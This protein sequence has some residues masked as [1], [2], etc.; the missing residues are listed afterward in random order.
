MGSFADLHLSSNAQLPA[1]N[2]PKAA[3][4]FGW[5]RQLVLIAALLLLGMGGGMQR[6]TA[7]K[8]WE[9]GD[10][11]LRIQFRLQ[12]L[13]YSYVEPTG[14]YDL[15]TQRAIM[16]FQQRIG[17][18][19]D[20]VV[21]RQTR[22]VLFD[23]FDPIVGAAESS[24][25]LPS[26]NS[27]SLEFPPE[28]AT[29]PQSNSPSQGFPP[30]G[31][32]YSQFS[33]PDFPSQSNSIDPFAVNQRLGFRP[34]RR[35]DRGEEVQTL[36]FRLVQLGYDLGDIDGI[37]GVNTQDAV[38]RFQRDRG[39]FINGIADRETLTA[40]GFHTIDPPN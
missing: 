20:G 10:E 21:G 16:D 28:G 17:L 38:A 35:G 22:P 29:Y 2:V 19:A 25:P 4:N 6:A 30:E 34:L 1:K 27:P 40:L 14:I 24:S 31:T 36:Q 15:N 9:R 39:L 3:L 8:L 18:D 12:A 37:Y 23:T 5:G 7:Q 33:F 32:T 11:V 26:L 13:G